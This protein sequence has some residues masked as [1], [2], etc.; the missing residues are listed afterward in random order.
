MLDVQFAVLL[1]WDAWGYTYVNQRV[2]EP[3]GI[4]APISQQN[5]GR[6][7]D[8]QQPCSTRKITGLTGAQIHLDR[9]ALAVTNRMQLGISATLG[10]PDQPTAP[11]FFRRLDAVR[12]ALR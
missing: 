5:L 3:V 2:T 7:Q 10:E 1:G 4:I 9:A 8:R 11:P 6:R 12:C